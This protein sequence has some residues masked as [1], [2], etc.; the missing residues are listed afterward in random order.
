MATYVVQRN[1]SPAVIARKLGHPGRAADLIAANPQKQKT[2][3]DGVPTFR[4]LVVG[5]TLNIPASWNSLRGLGRGLG[6]AVD[7]DINAILALSATALCDGTG[8]TAITQFQNDYNATGT[9]TPLTVTGVY[10]APTA[11]ALQA[12]INLDSSGYSFT[13]TTAPAACAAAPSTGTTTTGTASAAIIAAA[14]AVI[15]DSTICNG[16]PN[17]NVSAFQTAYN[18]AYGAS[19]TV[20]GKYGT[21]TAAAMAS[22]S[23]DATAAGTPLTGTLPAACSIYLPSG[24]GAPAPAPSG[25]TT[26]T[27]TTITTA[28]TTSV[29]PY[30]LGAFAVGGLTFYAL[31]RY[32]GPASHAHA[33][34][35]HH[36]HRHLRHARA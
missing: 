2:V 20:D 32:K 15:A 28:P 17:S 25:G 12:Q 5:E 13:S 35:H 29:W 33:R 14:N 21:A 36:A 31:K 6:A 27:T 23:Q 7:D 34:P 16:T 9:S 3:I 26:T 10:D 19:L 1:D 8:Q 30:V 22:V 18:A 24:G 4:S 11:G